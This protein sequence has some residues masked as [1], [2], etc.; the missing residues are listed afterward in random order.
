MLKCFETERLLEHWYVVYVHVLRRT[1]HANHLRIR[2]RQPDERYC[3]IPCHYGHSQVG[4]HQINEVG[5][6]AKHFYPFQTIGRR[7]DVVP[8]VLKICRDD[9]LRRLV[10]FYN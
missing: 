1:G 6:G 7:Q 5:A 9:M 8:D 4:Q 3:F 2:S 10:I